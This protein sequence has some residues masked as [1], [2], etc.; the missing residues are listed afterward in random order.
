MIV[1][2]DLA[3]RN[4]SSRTGFREERRE[5]LVLF[6]FLCVAGQGV[7]NPEGAL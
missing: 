7:A 4:A 2:N 1:E 3:K 6:Q 5:Q